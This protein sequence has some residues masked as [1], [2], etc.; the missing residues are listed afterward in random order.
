M[1]NYVILILMANSLVNSNLKNNLNKNNN[2]IKYIQVYK[3]NNNFVVATSIKDAIDTYH[4]SNKMVKIK[5]IELVDDM[6]LI[7]LDTIQKK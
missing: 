3:I 1:V 5:S 6:S 7:N 4:L 2:M